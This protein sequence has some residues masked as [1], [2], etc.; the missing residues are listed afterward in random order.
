M[1]ARRAAHSCR[2][3]RRRL[4]RRRTRADV[5]CREPS[6][7]LWAPVR[8]T[9]RGRARR[10]LAAAACAGAV[11]EASRYMVSRWQSLRVLLGCNTLPRAPCTTPLASLQL[12][13]LIFL[14]CVAKQSVSRLTC[15]CR[16]ALA[17]PHAVARVGA[18]GRL[19]QLRGAQRVPEPGGHVPPSWH[20]HHAHVRRDV[21]LAA[22]AGG[23]L[24][25]RGPAPTGDSCRQPYD[26]SKPAQ[27]PTGFSLTAIHSA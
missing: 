16:L 14:Q 25:P 21:R 15:H 20:V 11:H 13:G 12:C 27:R 6:R 9:G 7:P 4:H 19:L 18:D 22:P 5:G 3:R 17:L 10:R 23:V 24:R 8:S 26:C 2:G 1:A